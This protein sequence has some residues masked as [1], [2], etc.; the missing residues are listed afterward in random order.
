VRVVIKTARLGQP[1]SLTTC[2]R[3]R[4][5]IKV[6]PAADRKGNPLTVRRP[7]KRRIRAATATIQ[8]ICQGP[9]VGAITGGKEKLIGAILVRAEGELR[10]VRR[11]SRTTSTTGEIGKRRDGFQPGIGQIETSTIRVSAR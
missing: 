5:D 8:L 1:D 3:Q 4:E 9:R 10:P 2:S 6:A 11:K 7:G